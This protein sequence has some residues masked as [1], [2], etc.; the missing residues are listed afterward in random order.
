MPLITFTDK[1]TMNTNSSVPAINK[2]TSGNVNE[3]KNVVN[4]NWNIRQVATAGLSSDVSMSTSSNYTTLTLNN[5][6]DATSN[7]GMTLG[8]FT[9][10]TTGAG[11]GI[12]IPAGISKVLVSGN[13]QYTNSS[14][15][16]MSF[17]NYVYKYKASDGTVGII[18]RTISRADASQNVSCVV[19]PFVLSV[20]EG[21]IVFLRAYKGASGNAA[22]V[23]SGISRTFLTVEGIE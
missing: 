7:S 6:I 12:K 2:I 1:Q 22:T 15:G 19:A 8:S 10:T 14:S 5:I 23:G 13:I 17:I 18:A 16:T 20:A 9:T 11:A 4:T 21:D 3:I